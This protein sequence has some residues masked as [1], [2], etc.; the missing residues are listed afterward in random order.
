MEAITS[1]PAQ[2]SSTSYWQPQG[3]V[4]GCNDCRLTAL[5]NLSHRVGRAMLQSWRT[6]NQH[7]KSWR[8]RL[9]AENVLCRYYQRQR[10]YTA[11]GPT[12]VHR[13]RRNFVK[14]T[15]KLQEYAKR[16]RR[17]DGAA[18]YFAMRYGAKHSF[19]RWT[20]SNSL[21]LTVR[22]KSLSL[23]GFCTD[24]KTDF[25]QNEMVS[26]LL[27]SGPKNL[28]IETTIIILL[29]AE[30]ITTPLQVGEIG[31]IDTN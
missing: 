5:S 30:R 11:K 19:I 17:S 20:T 10:D 7:C 2:S 23:V 3:K 6:W 29:I 24:Q 12:T 13:Q 15:T 16:Y 9:C 25:V 26:N 31:R 22:S 21:I 14:P 1:P 27:L 18:V 8:S 28:N 4:R